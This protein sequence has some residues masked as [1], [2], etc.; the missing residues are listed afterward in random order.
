METLL[1]ETPITLP[2][3]LSLDVVDT[4]ACPRVHRRIEIG[5]LP[6][7]GRNL[8]VGMLKLFEEQMRQAFLRELRIH[9][10][11]RY[12]RESQ[13]PGSE[14]GIFPSIG[15]GQDAHG[16]QMTPMRVT[17]IGTRRRR[18]RTGGISVH[19]LT[20]VEEIDLLAP[21]QTGEGA[22][23]YLTLLG[24]CTRWSDTGVERVGFCP[25]TLHDL[26]HIV[27]RLRGYVA[28]EAQTD[29]LRLSWLN[30]RGIMQACLGSRLRRVQAGLAMD[31][32]AMKS[33][34]HETGVRSGT[35]HS[36]GIGFVVGEQCA[37]RRPVEASLA[38]V[39][40]KRQVDQ[41]GRVRIVGEKANSFVPGCRICLGLRFS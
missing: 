15:N 38:K 40:W 8:A 19:P 33:V 17:N 21:E 30:Q 2:G 10:R 39:V 29:N 13:V 41:R 6:L 4:P 7:I 27:E 22:T 9:Q 28:G 14:P 11:E 3:L 26:V 37:S 32:V 18:L 24:I 36:R 25:A 5:E 12:A 35:R 20:Y 34:F 16:I 23:L 1:Q 31:D